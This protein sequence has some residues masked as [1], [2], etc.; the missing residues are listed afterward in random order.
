M[1]K[2]STHLRAAMHDGL[3]VLGEG[4]GLNCGDAVRVRVR[5]RNRE[6]ARQNPDLPKLTEVPVVEWSE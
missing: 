6:R 5:I 4:H 1:L 2:G 3:P